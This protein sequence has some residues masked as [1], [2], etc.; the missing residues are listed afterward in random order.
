MTG[1]SATMPPRRNGRP[2]RED[3]A[4]KIVQLLDTAAE[5]FIRDGYAGAS[6]DRIA[7][8][9][10]V[11]KPTIYA[12]FGSKANL[13]KMV[14]EHILENRLVAIDDR[15]TACTA[16]EGLKEQLANII[17]A[18]TE[19]MFVGIFRLFL[20]EANNFPEIFAAFHSTTELQSKRLLIEHLARHR[21]FDSLKASREETAGILLDM[22]SALVVMTSVRS[23]SHQT[24]SARQEASRIVDV[25]LHGLLPA[26]IPSP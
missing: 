6:I 7:A 23:D 3:A 15:I 19:P 22:V 11:G 14:I 26:Q 8:A 2:R 20:T 16:E 18:S 10:G 5:I 24:L 12:R 21:E 25:I 17:T 9:A 4:R 13:L 1:I